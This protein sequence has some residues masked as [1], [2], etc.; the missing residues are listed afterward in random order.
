MEWDEGD[1]GVEPRDFVPETAFLADPR[2]HFSDTGSGSGGTGVLM[3]EVYNESSA[4]I[5]SGSGITSGVG[6]GIGEGYEILGSMVNCKI[7]SRTVDEMRTGKKIMFTHG[8]KTRAQDDIGSFLKTQIH[9]NGVT[10]IL[11]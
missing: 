2:K 7:P 4:R 8:T 5:G 6:I 1:G 10:R 3:V 9:T 11:D